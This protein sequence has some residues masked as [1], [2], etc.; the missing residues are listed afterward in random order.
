MTDGRK[1]TSFRLAASAAGL[2]LCTAAAIL[3]LPACERRETHELVQING[4]A[5]GTSYHIKVVRHALAGEEQGSSPSRQTLEE[6]V[7]R[8]L[9]RVN[10]KMSTWQDDSELSRF[11]QHDSAEPFALSADTLYVMQAA[12]QVSE[13]TDGAFDITVGP[14]VNAWGFG[15]EETAGP[16]PDDKLQTLQQSVGY[17]KL[18]LEISKEGERLMDI[19]AQLREQPDDPAGTALKAH[20][21]VYADLSAI[22]KGYVVDRIAEAFLLAGA[23]DFMVEIGGEVRAHGINAQERIWRI[24]IVNPAL[25]P[26]APSTGIVPL[27]DKAMATSGDY[28]NFKVDE[29]GNRYHHTIDPRL[30]RPVSHALASATVVHRSCMYADAYATALMVM[31]PEEALDW[32]NEKNLAVYLIIHDGED[33]TTEMSSGF[34]DLIHSFGE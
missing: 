18:L 16:P 31:G 10:E 5:L 2:F 33:F 12:L 22:A 29:A 34:D 28:R 14:L 26:N 32:A 21:D 27:Q 17:D 7:T 9:E 20:P 11:N 4:E 23:E 24:G 1:R 25:D 13:E 6:I 3:L 30:G 8:E 15:P 19:K